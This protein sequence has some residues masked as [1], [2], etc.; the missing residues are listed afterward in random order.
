MKLRPRDLPA[1]WIVW[2]RVVLLG[3]TTIV[4]YG[5]VL[6]SFGVFVVPIEEDTGW[7]TSALSA[8]FSLSLLGGGLG[9]L[10]TGRVLDRVGSGPV[11][12]ST[13][14]AGSALLLVAAGAQSQTGFIL[15]WGFGAGI[16]SAGLFYSVTM[17]IT[18]R[19]F[20]DRRAQ[21]FAVLTFIGGLASPIYFP[22]AGVLI[23]TVDW[24]DTIRIMVVILIVLT[25]PTAALVRGA[26]ATPRANDDPDSDDTSH[27]DQGYTSLRQAFRSREVLLMVGMFALAMSAFS[28]LQ[29][30]HVPALQAAGLSLTTATT[31]AGVRGF[32][33]LPGRALLVPIAGRAGV[34][35][36]L[37]VMYF[38]MALG[39]GILIL[40]GSMVFI[41]IFAVITGLAFGTIAPLH[42][43]YATEVFGERR[44]GT[45]M[46]AQSAIVALAS[47]AGPLGV[48]VVV[49]G[50]GGY[51]FALGAIA[52]MFAASLGLLMIRPRRRAA[53][54]AQGSGQD[55]NGDEAA[56][57]TRSAAA[58]GD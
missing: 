11:M 21:A 38:T 22:L 10:L 50:S 6:Y 39:V 49:D 23:D 28:A 2:W 51:G 20:F 9:A 32:L 54:P 57:T 27:S 42:G 43:L 53:R 34:P 33:S 5:F 12:L 37:L 19:L 13:L 52:A 1:L 56:D 16:I 17:A 41:W 7:P 8:A 31:I 36:A 25:L 55:P 30:Y 3:V 46:G 26:A 15:S 4:S 45:L 14:L 40:A 47:A 58:S 35:S 18:A 48:G 29:V 24:R 44:I